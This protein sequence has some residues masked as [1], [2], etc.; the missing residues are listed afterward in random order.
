[1]NMPSDNHYHARQFLSA[2]AF[3]THVAL[4]NAPGD[5]AA[6]QS[7]PQARTPH[8][9]INHMSN[10]MVLSLRLLGQQVAWVDPIDD[11][12]AER[13]RFYQYVARTIQAFNAQPGPDARTLDQILQGPLADAMT[14]V[15]QLTMLRRFSGFPITAVGY[16][17]IHFAE[18]PFFQRHPE[19][20]ATASGNDV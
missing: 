20:L 14:H 11:F 19:L 8:Q 18:E 16:Y 4:E 12:H 1:M 3:R 5:F 15:G 10:L 9:L 6:L 2:L 7:A 13:D 17:K